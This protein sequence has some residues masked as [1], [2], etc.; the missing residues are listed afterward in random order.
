MLEEHGGTIQ[1]ALNL[2]IHSPRI[3]Y[4]DVKISG[5]N[6]QLPNLDLVNLVHRLCSKEGVRS[7]FY[8][9]DSK[10]SRWSIE[11][12]TKI[13]NEIFINIDYSGWYAIFDVES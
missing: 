11:S 1:A 2:E 7:T 12:L 3:S 13:S 8:N 9:K 10:V 4:L 5:L 6:G